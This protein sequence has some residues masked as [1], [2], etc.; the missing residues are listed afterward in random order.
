M[1]NLDS[2]NNIEYKIPKINTVV[3]ILSI[4]FKH[5]FPAQLKIYDKNK[6]NLTFGKNEPLKTDDIYWSRYSLYLSKKTWNR[7]ERYPYWVDSEGL[8]KMIAPKNKELN[9][10]E[11]MDIREGV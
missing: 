3:Y 8:L 1:I 7:I 5:L 4:D 11:I 10:F 2:W 9:R 6:C